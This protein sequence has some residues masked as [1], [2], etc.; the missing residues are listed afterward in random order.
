MLV[1]SRPGHLCDL[2][3]VA[4]VLVANSIGAEQS[5]HLGVPISVVP[6]SS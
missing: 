1:S 2:A 5:I 3:E 6:S 4:D